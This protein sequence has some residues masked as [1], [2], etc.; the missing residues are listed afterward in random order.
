M[1]T[2][3]VPIAARR[4]ADVAPTEDGTAWDRALAT[5]ATVTVEASVRAPW[6]T[7]RRISTAEVVTAT[8]TNFKADAEA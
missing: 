4:E 7:T 8:A 5:L 6:T 1:T 3:P 2:T